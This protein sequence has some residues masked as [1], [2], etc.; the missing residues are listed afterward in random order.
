M[1]FL[2]SA[3][4]IAGWMTSAAAQD[5]SLLNVS[6]DPTRELY[7]DFNKAFAAK[8]KA[9]TGKTVGHQG[10]AWRLRPSGPFGDRW[11]RRRCGDAGAGLRYRRDRR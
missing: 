5:I 4:A 9:D 8:Y 2:I 7:A 1:R 11:A 10:V 6:Y 3:L